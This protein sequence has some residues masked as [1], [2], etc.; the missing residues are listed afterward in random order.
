MIS[1]IK[2]FLPVSMLDWEGKLCAVIFMGGCSFRCPF[3][4]NPDLVLNPEALEDISWEGI[5]A[6]LEEKRG[7][8]DG[9]TVTGGEPTL[10]AE[11]GKLLALIR[12]QSLGVK[13]DTNGYQPEVLKDILDAQSADFIAMDVKSSPAGYA[14]AA[15]RLI[16]LG[17]I[18]RSIS[19]I[20]GSG[21]PHEFRCTVVPGFTELPDLL[22]IAAWI[23]GA[24]RLTLQQYQPS[25]ALDPAL[26]EIRAM[27]DET[28]HAWAEACSQ[29]VPTAVRGAGAYAPPGV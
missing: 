14:K 3:C 21:L 16:D 7:W 17:R 2:G 24:Q 4:H 27:P 25:E 26:R 28:L 13:L 15:G 29:V 10:H 22:Q 12:S 9:V 5:T 1:G 23:D 19:A 8:L 6:S 20:I 18:S 11:L